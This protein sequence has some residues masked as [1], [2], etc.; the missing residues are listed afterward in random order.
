M[1]AFIGVGSRIVTFPL[2]ALIGGLRGSEE[3]DAYI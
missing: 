2:R 1:Q 3:D